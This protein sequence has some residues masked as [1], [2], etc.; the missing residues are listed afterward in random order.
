MALDLKNLTIEKAHAMLVAKE[1]SVAELVEAHLAH[2]RIADKEIHA[3]IELFEHESD[4]VAKAQAMI[5]AGTATMLTGIPYGIKDN[6]LVEGHIASAGSRMLR[7][8]TA[9][10]SATVI[11]KLDAVGAIPMGRTNM[12]DAAMGSSTES[13]YY[14]PT[15]NP[16][17][18]SRVPGGSSGGS[19]AAVAADMCLFALGTDTG[20]SVRQPAS[21][22]GI[23]GM[24]PTYGA[25]SRSGA[26]P[27]G[28][29][30][31]QIAPFAKNVAEAKVVFD[32]IKGFDGM[33]A[34][35]L[36]QETRA[37]LA[38][39][40][41]GKVIGVPR[42][43]L[44]MEGINAEVK[45][46]FDASIEKLKTLGYEIRDIELPH[47]HLSL[48]VYYIIMPAEVSTN[49]SRLD[50]MR[51]AFRAPGKD[52]LETYMKTKY[53]GFGKE[54]RRRILLGTYVLS[55]GYY[56]AYYNKAIK[57]RSLIKSDY[58]KV[59]A[60][61]VDSVLVPT[62]PSVAFKPGEKSDPLSMYLADIFTVTA[63]LCHMPA[64]SVPSGVDSEGLPF[65]IQFTANQG[66]EET[67]FSIANDFE[68]NS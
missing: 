1:I 30:L 60:S 11:K 9:S 54:V 40:P 41:A 18:T 39:K 8:Y 53:E 67:M 42:H 68:K 66:M 2:A 38:E 52:L 64:I 4:R 50:G 49:L 63:N 21:F 62:S 28:S 61:G 36:T 25:V 48:A 14:G 31:D 65:G 51:Y 29:S 17:N 7:D 56:D 58:E 26:I 23:V 46:N 24:V 57:V 33:D 20:G 59:F 6:I 15:K 27:M 34:Q 19:A 3:F 12:D 43:L 47:A 13:S 5:D 10:Y 22:C 35:T 37:K 55:A 16:R 45:A 32:V 44:E